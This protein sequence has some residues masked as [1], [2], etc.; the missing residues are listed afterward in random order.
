[1]KKS[2]KNCCF[3]YSLF[4]IDVFFYVLK[5]HEH[6]F[7]FHF[8]LLHKSFRFCALCTFCFEKQ[9]YIYTLLLCN[10]CTN[11]FYFRFPLETLLESVLYTLCFFQQVCRSVYFDSSRCSVHFVSTLYTCH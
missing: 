6:Y 5:T 10:K 8:F 9:V 2:D 1:M 3:T 4:N 11:T 7:I